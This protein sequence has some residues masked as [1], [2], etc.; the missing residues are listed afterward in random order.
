MK[1]LAM[2]FPAF[3]LVIATACQTA[4]VLSTGEYIEVPFQTLNGKIPV[5]KVT[6]NGKTAWMIVDTGASVTVVNAAVANQ[7]GFLVAGN[8]SASK[9]EMASLAGTTDLYATYSCNINIGELAIK[10]APKAQNMISLM[11][12]IKEHDKITIVGILGSD[13]LSKYKMNINYAAQTI[14]YPASKRSADSCP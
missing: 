11:S 7:Y 5:L 14:T 9:T 3:I 6:I 12:R 13:V 1:Y 2:L 10:Y 4:K 8:L